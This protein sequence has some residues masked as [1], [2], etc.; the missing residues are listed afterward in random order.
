MAHRLQNQQL[1]KQLIDL[2]TL[3]IKRTI[4]PKKK[5]DKRSDIGVMDREGEKFKKPRRFKAVMHN[6]DY[7]P[8]ELVIVI[9]E[10]IFNKSSAQATRLMLDVHKKG[11]GVVGI[12]SREICETKCFHAMTM[13]KENGYPFL[14]ESEPE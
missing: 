6:D 10:S 2:T 11:K 8:M 7:T 13:A 4:V 12:Y 9:L 14:I 3:R 1:S 5:L